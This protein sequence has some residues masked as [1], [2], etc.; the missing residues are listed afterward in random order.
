MQ[1]LAICYAWEP[2]FAFSTFM[3]H[4]L[5]IRAPDGWEMQWFRGLAWCVSRSRSKAFQNAL[6]WGA[7]VICLVDTDHVYDPDV[8]ERLIERY[9]EGYEIVAPRIPMR[10]YIKK[11]GMKPFQ[12][13]GWRF[14]DSVRNGE[15]DVL[16]SMLL[17]LDPKDGDIQW[18]ELPNPGTLLFPA[19][20]LRNMKQPWLYEFIDRKTFGLHGGGDTHFVRRLQVENNAKSWIDLTIEVKHLNIFAIDD[21]YSQRFA[22][23][24]QQGVGDPRLCDFDIGKRIN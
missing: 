21:T 9:E 12:K 22:D 11:L 19:K 15:K 7:D 4:A 17:P 14:E 18:A 24:G 6:D 16:D 13:I 5:N 8:M 1:K 3:E 20:F 10:G 2:P 23:W